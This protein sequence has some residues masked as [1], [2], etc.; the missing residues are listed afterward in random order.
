MG[1]IDADEAIALFERAHD[2]AG[3]VALGLPSA[4]QFEDQLKNIRDK[5]LFSLGKAGTMLP[6]VNAPNLTG[7]NLYSVMPLRY[8]H[9][10]VP[11]SASLRNIVDLPI[12]TEPTDPD[13]FILSW[14]DT[15]ETH[16]RFDLES[17]WGRPII[18]ITNQTAVER[19]RLSHRASGQTDADLFTQTLGLG[20]YKVDE[21]AVLITIP[22]S[23]VQKAGHYRP[24]FADAVRHRFF[25]ARSSR[26][27]AKVGNWGQTA[28]LAKLATIP[29][30]G[31]AERVS[32]P[33][34]RH[35][36][37][38]RQKLQ[39]ALLE[40]VTDN[41]FVPDQAPPELAEGVWKRRRG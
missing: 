40:R 12:D 16:R 17:V 1:L 22:G 30:D 24:T 28:H 34:A 39:V 7:Q 41:R 10:L 14:G 37:H 5:T 4:I 31:C 19:A 25:M 36:F 35:H 18:W 13:G 6:F 3:K 33:I 20:H 15:T 29:C 32:L 11:G 26:P 21:M 9:Y 2:E 27:L 23:V 8:L 38:P